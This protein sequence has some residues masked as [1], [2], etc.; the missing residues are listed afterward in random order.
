MQNWLTFSIKMLIYFIF[1]LLSRETVPM[2][3]KEGLQD[4][5]W[6]GFSFSFSYFSFSQLLVFIDVHLQYQKIILPTQGLRNSWTME[7]NKPYGWTLIVCV[8]QFR[9]GNDWQTGL[10]LIESDYKGSK[11][12]VA[13]V[14]SRALLV[15]QQKK[16]A[17][18]FVSL[19]VMLIKHSPFCLPTTS[20]ASLQVYARAQPAPSD[21][22]WG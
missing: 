18:S 8:F 19:S 6:V 3:D 7:R 1:I 22:V 15:F 20:L 16:R 9:W 12:N 14:V 2:R 13:S 11:W 10:R 4:Y 17:S 21:C 5:R